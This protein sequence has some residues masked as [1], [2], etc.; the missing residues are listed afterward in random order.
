MGKKLNVVPLPATV[1]REWQVFTLTTVHL[2]F[3]RCCSKLFSLLSAEI[4]PCVGVF[5]R[6]RNLPD[7]SPIFAKLLP[8][9]SS[10]ILI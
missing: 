2:Y 8:S 10:I 7:F 1:E 5:S 9:K 6:L 4:C 3:S